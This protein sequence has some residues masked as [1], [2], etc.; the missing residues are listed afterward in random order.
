MN[1]KSLAF[2]PLVIFLVLLAGVGY[3]MFSEVGTA[4]GPTPTPPG[5][6]TPATVVAAV[7]PTISAT[8]P[9]VSSPSPTPTPVSPT[10]TDTPTLAPTATFTS[11]P[12]DTPTSTN[13]YTLTPTVTHTPTDTP[14]PTLTPTLTAT[15]VPTPTPPPGAVVIAAN[16]A[17]LYFGPGTIYQKIGML[18]K[19]EGLNVRGK[20][21]D[22]KWIEASSTTSN[23]A[24]WVQVDGSIQLK[25][26][27]STIS[28]VEPPISSTPLPPPILIAPEDKATGYQNR[29][30]LSWDW[31]PLGPNDYYRI[32]IW[33]YYNDCCEFHRKDDNTFAENVEPIDVAWIRDKNYLYDRVEQAYKLEYKW[34]VAVIRYIGTDPLVEKDWAR[35]DPKLQVWDPA[36]KEKFVLITWPSEMRMLYVVPG[37]EP[38]PCTGNC[39]SGSGS[40]G[41]VVGPK[42]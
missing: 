3:V 37:D 10:P 31:G 16:G 18:S 28:P 35:D 19:G 38:P 32:E 4:T 20:F 29:A 23:V 17:D 1:H 24:G 15:P 41:G 25:I 5:E 14:P 30:G 9:L 12:T 2:L 13:T 8:T 27:L 40:G 33:N 39:S 34:R 7:S 6:K 42:D 36:P 21:A 26:D 11:S 22:D